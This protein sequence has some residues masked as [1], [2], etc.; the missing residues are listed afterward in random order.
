MMGRDAF[1]MELLL[2][3]SA[4]HPLMK[5]L[6][7]NMCGPIDRAP[8]Y[9]QKSIILSERDPRLISSMNIRV[10][11]L[12][13]KFNKMDKLNAIKLETNQQKHLS[14]ISFFPSKKKAV[15][16]HKGV[17]NCNYNFPSPQIGFALRRNLHLNTSHEE[18]NFLFI[19]FHQMLKET[20]K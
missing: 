1:L 20:G 4:A 3:G 7:V 13:G 11:N 5:S 19:S 9:C 15:A 12:S 14:V 8:V 16:R 6:S 17:K 2:N 18:E 10:I